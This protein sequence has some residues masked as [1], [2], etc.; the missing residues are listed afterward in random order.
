MTPDVTQDL[1]PLRRVQVVTY[2]KQIGLS[3]VLQL[4]STKLGHSLKYFAIRRLTEVPGRCKSMGQDPSCLGAVVTRQRKERLFL[5]TTERNAEQVRRFPH[6]CVALLLFEKHFMLRGKARG[7]LGSKTA[8]TFLYA[9][10]NYLHTPSR[11]K[12]VIPFHYRA[13][14]AETCF[15]VIPEVYF[16]RVDKKKSTLFVRFFLSA[17]DLWTATTDVSLPAPL[18]QPAPLRTKH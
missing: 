2:V 1:L 3:A 17:V 5:Q 12:I 7:G 4:L 11:N 18:R 15:L 14:Q 8:V 9:V 6:V 13:M 16:C 10:I